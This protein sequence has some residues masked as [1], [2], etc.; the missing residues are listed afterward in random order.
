ML[1]KKFVYYYG[2][3]NTFP[4]KP[5]QTGSVMF[6]VWLK[7]NMVMNNIVKFAVTR[8][9]FEKIRQLAQAYNTTVSSLARERLLQQNYGLEKMIRE[10]YKEVMK[11]TEDEE[12]FPKWVL[13]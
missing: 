13:N 5:H 4:A 8:E 1:I 7:L 2:V 11:M 9:Q 3:I 6:P 12:R 10:I